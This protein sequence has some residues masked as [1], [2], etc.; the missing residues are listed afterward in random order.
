MIADRKQALRYSRA[1]LVARDGWWRRNCRPCLFHR[2]SFDFPPVPFSPLVGRWCGTPLSVRRE[3]ILTWRLFAASTGIRCLPQPADWGCL[4]RMP[5]MPCRVPSPPSLQ[6]T[7]CAAPTRSGDGCGRGC[8]PCWR[9]R[10]ATDTD[11]PER[12]P[13]WLSPWSAETCLRCVEA[14]LSAATAPAQQAIRF[15]SKQIYISVSSCLN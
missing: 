3:G 13:P 5:A 6:R 7:P 15:D 14:D 4:R 1:A 11:Q 10:S 2:P 8:S 12:S 9:I